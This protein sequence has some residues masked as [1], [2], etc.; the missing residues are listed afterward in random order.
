MVFEKLAHFVIRRRRWVVATWILLVVL[1]L[2]T[3]SKIGDRWFESFSIPGYSAYEANQRTLKTFGSGAQ[4][5]LVA[6]F[7][8]DG[9]VTQQRG[10]AQA[11]IAA[12]G[13]NRG[14]RTASYF[15]TGSD[16]YVSKDRHTTFATIYPPG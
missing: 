7:R 11:I 6:V 8:S 12:A 13:V 1:G 14:S 16:A 3:T 2:F 10:I 9:D 15:S 4:P 5:P